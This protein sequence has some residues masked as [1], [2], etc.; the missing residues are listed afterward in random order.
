[1]LPHSTTSPTTTNLTSSHLLTWIRSSITPADLSTLHLLVTLFSLLPTP[2]PATHLKQFFPGHCLPN[3]RT[4]HSEFCCHHNSSFEYSSITLTFPKAQ[5]TPHCSIYCDHP[6]HHHNLNLS[7]PLLTNSHRFFPTQPPSIMHSS[8][9]AT[10]ISMLTTSTIIKQSILFTS[11]PV[12][13]SLSMSN[14][15][16]QTQSHLRSYHNSC[17]YYPNPIITSSIL[18]PQITIQFLLA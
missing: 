13:T 17:Q 10:S 9:L 1:M 7:L 2:T 18:S 15:Y 14:C 11:L 16:S 12:V 4:F 6:I 8:L 3:K 5:L